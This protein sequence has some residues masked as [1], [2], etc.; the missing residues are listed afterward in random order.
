MTKEFLFKDETYKIIGA[1]MESD[2]IQIW[3]DV[4][5]IMTTDP[6]IVK[7]AKN[8]PVVSFSEAAELAYF[9]A[10]VLHPKTIEPA[11]RKNIPVVVKNTYNP[12]HAGTK[13][14]SHSNKKIPV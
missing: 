10:K 1:A 7:Q 2:E 8:V 11:M 14:L 4:D 13:I 5:G 3:T 9:G 12:G 6:R